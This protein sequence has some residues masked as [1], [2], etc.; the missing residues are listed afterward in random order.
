MT[1]SKFDCLAPVG[2][3]PSLRLTEVAKNLELPNFITQSPDDDDR[4]FILTQK[5]KILILK[6]GAVL[7]KPFLDLSSLVVQPANQDER[8]LLG[9]AFHPD[10]GKNGRFFVYYT[11]KGNNHQVL[12]EYARGA[13]A[14]TAKPEAV[15][16]LFS[17]A[18]PEGNHNGG[19]IA[20]SPKDGML[21]IGMGDGGSAGDPHG[22]FGNGQNLATKWGKIHRIDVSSTPYKIPPG[23]MTTVP[24]GNPTTGAVVP[25]IW[26]YGLR[27]PWRFSFDACTSDLYIGD[28]GQDFWEEIDVEPA[29]KGNLNYGWKVMEAAKC[30][31]ALKTP[32]DDSCDKSGKVLPVESYL[33]KSSTG[34]NVGCS[35]TGGYV[36]RGSAIPALRGT[37]I[38]G[39][40]CTGSIW[41]FAWSA[42]KK[43]T[44]VELT[45]A[46]GSNGMSIGSFGQ[47]NHGEVYVV[48]RAGS[49][50]KLQ[51]RGQVR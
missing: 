36:Y 48:D 41:S 51:D 33:H 11:D 45:S 22:A 37:Y 28:V 21:Y 4:F 20:F 19:M 3:M 46:L 16:V 9:L 47:D 44:T 5:G 23:N 50:Y 2:A 25:E 39:D 7:D 12:A 32:P 38:Y 26:D 17:E 35:V 10:Y 24:A 34:A 6:G 42:G 49:I 27:N 14:E 30:F 29:G 1:R 43:S 13:D 8:G 40:Y 18:D 15:N 31:H